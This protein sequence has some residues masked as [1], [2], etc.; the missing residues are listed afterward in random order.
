MIITISTHLLALFPPKF[1]AEPSLFLLG[2]EG[3]QWVRADLRGAASPERTGPCSLGR[4]A[5]AH[6]VQISL[7]QTLGLLPTSSRHP[8]GNTCLHLTQHS[9]PAGSLQIS[10]LPERHTHT[11]T[12]THTSSRLQF[13]YPLSF[14][15]SFLKIYFDGVRSSLWHMRSSSLTRGGTQGP[16]IGIVKSQP[17]DPPPQGSPHFVS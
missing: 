16:H 8:N 15:P 9:F 4:R 12:H 11:H 13:L 3:S 6:P 5:S 14:S 17:L 7:Q 2:Q 1:R 10:P